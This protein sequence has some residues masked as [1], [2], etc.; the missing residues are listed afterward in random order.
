[1]N[2][3]IHKFSKN[4]LL[5]VDSEILFSDQAITLTI[6]HGTDTTLGYSQEIP[7]RIEGAQ[8][9]APYIEENQYMIVIR[10][11]VDM[12]ARGPEDVT[13]K[14]VGEDIGQGNYKDKAPYRPSNNDMFTV[15]R[16]RGEK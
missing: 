3:K 4:S 13:I 5:S 2:S 15:L 6:D 12:S 16:N 10:E 8:H 11:R 7:F 1:M 14:N 9:G